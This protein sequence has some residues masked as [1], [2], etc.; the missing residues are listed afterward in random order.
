VTSSLNA[1]SV[2]VVANTVIAAAGAGGAVDVFSLGPVHLVIDI[3]G[4][5][6]ADSV[7][8]SV[9]SLSGAVDFAG[10]NGVTVQP[11]GGPFIQFAAPA[12]GPGLFVDTGT[13]T[14]SVVFGL[15]GSSTSAARADHTS[16]GQSWGGGALFGL[17]LLGSH[18]GGTWLNLGNSSGNWWN[19]IST[20]TGNG[21]GAGKFLIRD[22]N[23]VAVQIS[24][25][26]VV[27][28]MGQVSA[29][30]LPRYKAWSGYF[31]DF[32]LDLAAGTFLEF[33]SGP[34]GFTVQVPGPG[35]LVFTAHAEVDAY[36]VSVEMILEDLTNGIPSPEVFKSQIQVGSEAYFEPLHRETFSVKKVVPLLSGGTRKYLLK[37][38]NLLSNH[39][40]GLHSA[41]LVAVWYPLVQAL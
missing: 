21:E 10:S 12:P 24:P 3:N 14:T 32:G 35:A 20:G 11:I 23:Q 19:L 41:S 1:T 33:P 26:G 30:N 6:A 37:F 18:P 25:G 36:R 39:N 13:H 15:S 29:P 22:G 40:V 9:N 2:R 31:P 16:F 34:D 27:D 8:T 7:V 4:Y 5:F 17:D 28:V 38:N